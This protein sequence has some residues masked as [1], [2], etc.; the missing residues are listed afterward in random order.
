MPC[1]G[2]H[3]SNADSLNGIYFQRDEGR[4]AVHLSAESKTSKEAAPANRSGL[5]CAVNLTAMQA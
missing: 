3:D 5:F 4:F 2:V 1:M